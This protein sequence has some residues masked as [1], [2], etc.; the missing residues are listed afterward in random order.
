MAQQTNSNNTSSGTRTPKRQLLHLLTSPDP[1]HP[2][3]PLLLT[4]RPTLRVNHDSTSSTYIPRT[5]GYPQRRQPND[6]PTSTATT[7]SFLQ[8]TLSPPAS[9]L[10][11]TPTPIPTPTPV[12]LWIFYVSTY[13]G[14]RLMIFE[15]DFNAR[16]PAENDPEMEHWPSACYH[17]DKL[18]TVPGRIIS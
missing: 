13:I 15:R 9:L 2:P 12:L 7:S 18:Q 4:H 16:L 5:H 6:I 10:P 1:T 11:S 3:L 17:V 14:R 8:C